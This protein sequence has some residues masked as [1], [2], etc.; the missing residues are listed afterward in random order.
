[1]LSKEEKSRL[2]KHV[3]IYTLYPT[4]LIINDEDQHFSQMGYPKATITLGENAPYRYTSHLST[5]GYH[6][7]MEGFNFHEIAQLSYTDYRVM[8]SLYEDA[9]KA[10]NKANDDARKYNQK[11]LKAFD[12]KKSLNQYIQ[13]TN[14]PILLKAIEDGAIENSMGIEHPETWN[15]LMFARTAII[16]SF[17]QEKHQI[18]DQKYLMDKIMKEIMCICTYGYRFSLQNSIVYLPHYLPK[19]FK[20]IRKL[21]IQGRLLSKTTT[22]RLEIAK[23]I[24][25]LCQPIIDQNVNELFDL[26]RQSPHFSNLPNNLFSQDSEMAVRFG[27]QNNA[28]SQPQQTK[29]KY[30]ID[31]SDEEF[32]RMESLENQNEKVL[33]QQL[34]QEL[35][36]REKKIEQEKNNQLKN[37]LENTS[38]LQNKI[39]FTDI[40]SQPISHYGQIAM[41]TKNISI[42][43][44]NQLARKM[45]RER[46]YATK[47]T[48]KHKLEYARKLDQQNLYRASLD[49][50]VFMK[51]KEGHK[52]ELCVSILVDNSE[53]MSG[54]K[55]VNA[56]KGCYELARVMQT[57]HIPF[58]ILAHKTIGTS[59]QM[60]KIISFQE[61]QKRNT[62]DRI[63]SMHVSGGTHEDIALEYVLKELSEYQRRRKGFVFVLSDGDTHGIQRIHQLTH[64]YKKQKDIDIIGIGIQT[65]QIMETYPNHIYIKDLDDLP[66]TLIQKLKD[67]A[68]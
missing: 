57:L 8:S 4:Q 7:M 45:K 38:F 31:M 21:A 13:F 49:G 27:K 51:H 9:K 26:I 56:M 62:L 58:S 37:E 17:I 47:S 30:N 46:M 15:A 36:K 53:S 65:V 32:D 5:E 59:V 20:P 42:A 34:L 12:L 68:L 16:K 61:C 3:S 18:E 10:Q 55:I 35:S 11:Q 48:T 67:I 43:R 2:K 41:R 24:L 40:Q 33:Q 60:T 28:S 39:I 14:L 64:F 44:S 63:Y 6:L 25:E 1:M 29:S 19:H 66:D 54:E 50:R 52:K 23:K 22:E